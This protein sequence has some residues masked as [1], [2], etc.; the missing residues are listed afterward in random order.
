[1]IFSACQKSPEKVLPE[2]AIAYNNQLVSVQR[3]ATEHILAYYAAL[4]SDFDGDNLQELYEST[5][6]AL[7]SLYE[8]AQ[9][10]SDLE[11]N[12]SLQQALLDYLSGLQMAF[13]DYEQPVVSYLTSFTGQIYFLA[14]EYQE[15]IAPYGIQMKEA[16][17]RLD[18]QFLNVQS[19]FSQQYGYTLSVE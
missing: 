4:E 5:H 13:Q 7:V 12:T 2:E 8:E 18:T 6:Q 11:G 15:V 1:M 9:Q 3:Q 19:A 10:F 17:E 14:K 16:L